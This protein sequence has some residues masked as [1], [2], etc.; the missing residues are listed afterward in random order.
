MNTNNLFRL[1]TLLLRLHVQKV[2][3]RNIT[4]LRSGWDWEVAKG[5]TRSSSQAATQ[6]LSMFCAHKIL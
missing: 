4:H 3:N 6:Y 5:P 1:N 2:S